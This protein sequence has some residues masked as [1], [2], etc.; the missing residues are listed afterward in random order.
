MFLH[1]GWLHFLGNMLYLYIF[2]DNVEDR[3]GHARYLLFYVLC[4]VLAAAVPYLNLATI[5]CG[6]WQMGRAA[7]AAATRLDADNSAAAFCR[8][9]LVTACFYADQLLPQAAALAETV[10]AGDA[11]FAGKGD[12]IF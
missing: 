8:A 6:G 7:L 9:K 11:A 4:G 5:V 12:E 1:G 2:G 3:L 10:K